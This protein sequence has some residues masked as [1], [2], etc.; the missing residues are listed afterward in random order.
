MGI[1]GGAAGGGGAGHGGGGGHNGGPLGKKG[2]A[3]G[4]EAARDREKAER[5]TD[6]G[7]LSRDRVS[8]KAGSG[9]ARRRRPLSRVGSGRWSPDVHLPFPDEAAHIN[10]TR[11]RSRIKGQAGGFCTRARCASLARSA[12]GPGLGKRRGGATTPATP[13]A[14]RLRPPEARRLMIGPCRGTPNE[15]RPRRGTFFVGFSGKSR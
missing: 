11:G 9:C 4:A 14:E 1:G 13:G 15:S 10:A 8:M 7:A 3:T 12:A 2:A 6:T 5:E